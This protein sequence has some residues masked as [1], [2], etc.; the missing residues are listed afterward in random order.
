MARLNHGV[1]DL[2]ILSNVLQSGSSNVP[3]VINT[4]GGVLDVFVE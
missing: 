1:R 2:G 3:C 4:E